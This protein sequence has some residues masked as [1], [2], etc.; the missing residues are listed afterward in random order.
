MPGRF[1]FYISILSLG[2]VPL[3]VSAQIEEESAALSLEINS[4]A[5]QECFFEA[6]KQKGIENHDKVIQ[7]LLE[8]R[9]LGDDPIVDYELAK[10]YLQEGRTALALD[11]AL[12]A[13]NTNPAN[14][15]YLNTLV[16]AG[17]SQGTP[18]ISLVGRISNPPP[19]IHENMALILFEKREYRQAMEIL[20]SLPASHTRNALE[21]KIRDSLSVPDS[22]VPD[23]VLNPLTGEISAL[24]ELRLDGN[25]NMLLQ[26]SAEA[27]ELYP[28][29]PVFYYYQG[30]ALVN[31]NRA[32]QAIGVLEEGLSYLIDD[33]GLENKFYQTLA[34]AYTILGNASKANMY[35]SKIKP[36]F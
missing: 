19:S 34:D 36:G 26:R 13:V 9:Q 17:L 29:S 16:E 5:F 11:H 15:W 3:G 7:T 28:A 27:M 24:E 4:D 8:C 21:E 2:F 30:L 6:L 35:L 12:L 22:R 1:L 31:M 14:K 18:A 32:E 33:P 23:E 25:W 20:E 10:A